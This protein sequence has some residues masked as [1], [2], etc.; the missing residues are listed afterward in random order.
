MSSLRLRLERRLDDLV[1]KPDRTSRDW[2]SL[3][4]VL[5]LSGLAYPLALATRVLLATA[6]VWAF[7]AG[8]RIEAAIIVV[9]LLAYLLQAP[10]LAG[11]VLEAH[12]RPD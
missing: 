4:G 9:L 1:A 2:L 11:I 3:W 10:L 12:R 6:T 8:R 5:V 7:A